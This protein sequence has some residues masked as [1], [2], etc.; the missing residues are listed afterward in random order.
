MLS[1]LLLGLGLISHFRKQLGKATVAHKCQMQTKHQNTFTTLKHIHKLENTFTKVENTFTNSK[2]IHKSQKHTRKS[3]KHTR[4][5]KTHSQIENT[6]AI[7]K[8]I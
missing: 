6:F 7:R 5:S 2:H 4:K 3:R 8:H 1:V